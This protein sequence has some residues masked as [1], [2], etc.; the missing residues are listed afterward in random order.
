MHVAVAAIEGDRAS[1]TTLQILGD[2]I[3]TYGARNYRIILLVI[4]DDIVIGGNAYSMN[5]I[6]SREKEKILNGL[7]CSVVWTE[8]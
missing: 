2:W 4:H 6:F 5:S 7:T 3:E 8:Y 1:S